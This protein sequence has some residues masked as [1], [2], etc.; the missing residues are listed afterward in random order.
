MRFQLMCRRIRFAVVAWSSTE[1][2]VR[3]KRSIST[4]VGVARC[5]EAAACRV[6]DCLQERD[7]REGRSEDGDCCSSSEGST[8]DAGW[9]CKDYY[10]GP[11]LYNY[12]WVWYSTASRSDGTAHGP[13]KAAKGD[14][15]RARDGD[16]SRLYQV[17]EGTTRNLASVF[18][19]GQVAR[20][21]VRRHVMSIKRWGWYNPLMSLCCFIQS[22][23]ERMV[24]NFD[25][26]LLYEPTARML[27]P[28]N[29]PV[30]EGSPKP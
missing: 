21:I 18:L 9:T 15:V 4:D 1:V 26:V 30:T 13:G 16:S 19:L 3:V 17:M 23:V 27:Y 5:D 7:G 10:L 25:A 24:S 22:K 28:L 14:H 2:M 20:I 11:Q 8:S 12:S 6:D 29:R